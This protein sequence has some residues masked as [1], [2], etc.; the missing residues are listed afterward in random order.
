ML[1]ACTKLDLPVDEALIGQYLRHPEVARD[2][3]AYW[4]LYKNCL[5]YT[6]RCV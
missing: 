3:A 4:E 2:L 5:L 1:T 6:S